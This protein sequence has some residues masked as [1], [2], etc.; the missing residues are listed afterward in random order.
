[1]TRRYFVPDLDSQFPLVRLPDEE[2]QHALRVMRVRVGDRLELFDGSGQQCE[3]VVIAAS[4][5]DCE[6]RCESLKHVDREPDLVLD[7]A[8]A[9]PKPD[10]AKELV[11]S[12]TQLGVH[13]VLPVIFERTQ[14]GPSPSLIEK[15]RRVVVEASK[16]SRRNQLML[17]D[18]PQSLSAFLSTATDLS[19][20]FRCVAMPGGQSM[21]DWQDSNP[22]KPSELVSPGDNAAS[23]PRPVGQFIVGPEGGLSPDELQACQEA[24]YVAIGMGERILRI[25]TAAIAISARLLD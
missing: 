18:E 21:R 20:A 8:I 24:G 23:L 15:L 25:E 1:M 5:K 12:L 11:E 4:R 6:C 3:A 17:I 13:R 9:L 16:Q 10:R 14:R 7:I 22:W 19:T 2:A